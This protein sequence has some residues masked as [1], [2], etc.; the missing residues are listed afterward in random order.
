[1]EAE[2]QRKTCI[3]TKEHSQEG[4]AAMKS[5]RKDQLGENSQKSKRKVNI[6]GLV[7]LNQEMLM[8]LM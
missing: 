7:V 8:F 5:K 4:A 6:G 2:K 3:K 1:M